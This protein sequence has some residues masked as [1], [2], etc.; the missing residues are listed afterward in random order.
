MHKRDKV[1]IFYYRAKGS[2]QK[3]RTL[4]L[5]GAECVINVKE[6]IKIVL[7]FAPTVIPSDIVLLVSRPGML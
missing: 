7:S 1:V 6:M 3:K 4:G 2:L 5:G